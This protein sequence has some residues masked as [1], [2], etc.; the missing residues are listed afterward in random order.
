MYSYFTCR[1]AEVVTVLSF[2]TAR[3]LLFASI[4]R[5]KGSDKTHTLSATASDTRK[6]EMKRMKHY[7]FDLYLSH[8][9]Q[10]SKFKSRLR[11]YVLQY[12][13]LGVSLWSGRNGH[14]APPLT[15]SGVLTL[16]RTSFFSRFRPP[17]LS[18]GTWW[19]M[20]RGVC[21]V[22]SSTLAS[23]REETER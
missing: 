4:M 17:S 15:N 3:F 6:D 23:T 21:V 7:F 8:I 2:R 12:S 14:Q 11:S 20:L 9:C 22:A 13:G 19:F 16:L 5:E 10:V 18:P 1:L